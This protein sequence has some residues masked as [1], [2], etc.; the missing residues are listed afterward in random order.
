MS[1]Q[2][3]D[4]P[5]ENFKYALLNN[6]EIN[7]NA[8]NEIQW[9]EAIS[10]TGYINCNSMGIKSLKGI[11]AFENITGLRC[12]NN[13]LEE[14][15][16]SHNVVLEAISCYNN[17]LVRIDITKCK[18]LNIIFCDK[19]K[20]RS[21]DVSGNIELQCLQCYD[22]KLERIDI[23]KNI[24]LEYLYCQN[25]LLKTLDIT[26]TK[27]LKYLNCNDNQIKILDVSKLKELSLF[28]CERN[29]L[30]QLNIAH[31]RFEYFDAKTNPGLSCI[32]VDD[33][34]YWQNRWSSVIDEHAQFSLDCR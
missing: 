34:K 27:G 15:V 28:Y 29:L 2:L 32:Q 5:D 31:R 12:A 3:V 19:N 16:L 21:L 1:A 26:N 23:S 6:S 4:I 22:N 10:F 24:H 18:R 14:L 13:S 9:E 11:E 7:S 25:N 20:L 30:E 33:I 8:D 17:E